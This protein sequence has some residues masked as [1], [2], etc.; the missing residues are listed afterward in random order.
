VKRSGRYEIIWVVMHMCMEAMLGISLYSY[1]Y[2]K[3]AK[4]LRL[5]YYCLCLFINKI[6]EE[7]RR[8]SAWKARGVRGRGRGWGKGG[9]MA[10]TMYAYMN[11]LIKKKISKIL[12]LTRSY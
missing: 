12:I 3:L 7:G 4:L 1:S 5:F 6:G 11:K 2:L 10:Q 9:E 8:G